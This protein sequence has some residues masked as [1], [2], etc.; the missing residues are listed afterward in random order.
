MSQISSINFK[1]S[2]V[3]QAQH[4]DRLLPPNYLIGGDFEINRNSKEALKL[5]NQIISE[6]I[7]K[8]T[9]RT[10]QKFQ[11]KSYE[12][13]AV[14]NIKP[15]TT[16]QDLEKLSR[17]LSDKYGFQCYQIAI[18]RDEGHINE[19]GEKA[20]NHHAHLEFVTLDKETGKNRQ[21]DLTPKKLREIQTEVAEILQMERGVDKRL[22]GVKR[23][24]P[25]KYAQM[26]EQE[27]Q[28]LKEIK[29][30]LSSEK[31]IKKILEA[32]RKKLIAKNKELQERGEAPRYNADDYKELREIKNKP[33][34]TKDELE[35]ELQEFRDKHTKKPFKGLLRAK[36]DY[37]AIAQEQQKIIYDQ[38]EQLNALNKALEYEATHREA[39]IKKHTKQK[40]QETEAYKE[41]LQEKNKE[42]IK[43]QLES[44]RQELEKATNEAIE[45]KQRAISHKEFY[46]QQAE[47]YE[48]KIL[49]LN[50]SEISNQIRAE[51]DKELKELENQQKIINQNLDT[52]KKE[53]EKLKS[54]NSRL[55][56]IISKLWTK[57]NDLKPFIAKIK[58]F[59][60]K[61][62]DFIVKEHKND[63]NANLSVLEPNSLKEPKKYIRTQMKSNGEIVSISY[64]QSEYNKLNEK[65][66]R[67][68]SL[69]KNSIFAKTTK[70]QD[71]GIGR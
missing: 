23:I 58:P 26:K 33:I 29:Q 19:Q 4:N 36:T 57:F 59:I 38:A 69:L 48:Q 21:R 47:I 39:I 3:I 17:H 9:E 8:Y 32:E 60:Q 18:H 66:K 27:K 50:Q 16:M 65:Q 10:G 63:L 71:R 51:K 42:E 61:G 34:K 64:T 49:N 52:V 13:S 12:W 28:N 1:K 37:E 6:A 68:C 2:N 44:Q 5:K 30:E 40:D 20:I 45:A 54:E 46:E 62:K 43:K 70:K 31:E 41:L 15:D 14:C 7:E 35:K 25:R 55:K 53:N 22:S 24:E 67:E 11:A 56:K